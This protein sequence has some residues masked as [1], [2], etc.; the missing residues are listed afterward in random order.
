MDHL[1][2][3][4]LFFRVGVSLKIPQFFL[5][6]LF[7]RCDKSNQKRVEN[8]SVPPTS[9]LRWIYL[10]L[11]TPSPQILEKMAAVITAEGTSSEDR[12]LWPL[13]GS[14]LIHESQMN[15]FVITW[16]LTC[17]PIYYILTM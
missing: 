17:C 2:P 14:F 9:G 4:D 15:A 10:K 5:S 11:I 7:P 13:L 12:I 1:I 16:C 6:P 3:L 8:C